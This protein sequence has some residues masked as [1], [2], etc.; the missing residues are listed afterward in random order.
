MSFLSE[1]SFRRGIGLLVLV[2]AVLLGGTWV[3][4]KLA[5]DHLLN[6]DGKTTARDWAIFLVANVN[7]F[8][9]IAAG[10]QPSAASLTFF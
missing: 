6:Q 7:D 8:E 5:T 2:L 9:Q 4:V 10:E 1:I 3:T